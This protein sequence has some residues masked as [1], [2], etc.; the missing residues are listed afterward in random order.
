ML[1]SEL[2]LEESFLLSRMILLPKHSK[3]YLEIVLTGLCCSGEQHLM[4]SLVGVG[5][6]FES[7][8]N[9]ESRLLHG[10]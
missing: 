2:L 9:E 6:V 5:G 7:R 8:F 1:K 10:V 3:K 4:D